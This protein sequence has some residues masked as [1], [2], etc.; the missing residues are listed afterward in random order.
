MTEVDAK[1]YVNEIVNAANSLE[2][3]FKNNFE[4]MDLENT[5]IRTKMETI[6]QNAVSDL[7]KLKSD[8]Q[9]L[10]FDKI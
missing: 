9:D 5:I 8:I 10:K 6:V 3:S 7:E 1:N 2:K 4:D